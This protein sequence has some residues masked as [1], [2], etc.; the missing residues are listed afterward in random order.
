MSNENITN[1]NVPLVGLNIIN[2]I[3][4]LSSINTNQNDT[5]SEKR[6]NNLDITKLNTSLKDINVTKLNNINTIDLHKSI[7]NN[8]NEINEIN[9]TKNLSELNTNISTNVQK[10]LNQKILQQIKL[11]TETLTKPIVKQNINL[12]PQPPK[13]QQSITKLVP[14]L[15]TQKKQI[16][17]PKIITKVN[18]KVISE[19]PSTSIFDKIN[20]AVELGKNYISRQ[21]EKTNDVIEPVST[22][23]FSTKDNSKYKIV[24]PN[25]TGDTLKIDARRYY[26]PENIDLNQVNVG[27]RNR[28]DNKQINNTQGGI[29]TSFNPFTEASKIDRNKINNTSSFIGIDVNGKVKVGNYNSFSP[30][31]KISKTYK[32]NVSDFV[33]NANGTVRF[34]RWDDNVIINGKRVGNKDNHD[35]YVPLVKVIGDDGKPTIGSLNVLTKKGN[36]DSNSFGNITGGRMILKV[37]N[38]TKLISGSVDDIEKAFKEIKGN[39]KSVEI[40]S[41]DNGSYGRSLRTYDKKL[42]SNDLR[43]YDLQNTSGGNIAYLK[44]TPK[45]YKEEYIQTPNVRTTNDASYKTGH[46]LVN[47]DKG[48]VLHHTAYME[49]SLDGVKKRFTTPNGNSAHVVI[50]YNGAR[51]IYAK[52]EQVTFHAGESSF[53]G[54]NNVNDFMMGVEF[55]G[56]TNKKPLTQNQI[57]SFIEYIKPTL[58]KHNIPIENI[59]SHSQI[60]PG[61]KNDI[62]ANEYKRIISTLISK[63]VYKHK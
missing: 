42:T 31:D 61:R 29:I 56:D 20:N 43:K 62:S 46:S 25:I 36:K 50:G 49:N 27:Y 41:L 14:K 9:I 6:I 32:N 58:I 45:Q 52:P 19:E 40:Y 33:R 57:N 22:P 59:V 17:I 35:N 1:L 7:N 48:V 4:K 38:Q 28:G 34:A 24:N 13:P 55:Q 3:N 11:Q 2:P 15:V 51:Q 53:N 8:I 60:A 18:P 44:D 23:K 12:K 47:E 10:D 30:T 37:G 63:N 39:N 16:T 5:I 54:R 21:L 26:I